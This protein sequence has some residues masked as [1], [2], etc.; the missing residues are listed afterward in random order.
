[1][2]VT[3]ELMPLVELVRSGIGT[4]ASHE[5]ASVDEFPYE[6]DVF[7]TADPDYVPLSEPWR[8]RREHVIG[9]RKR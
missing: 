9:W 1:M 3:Y 6:I 7:G 2:T 5:I 8:I 4:R